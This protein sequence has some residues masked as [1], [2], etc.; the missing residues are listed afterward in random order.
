VLDK[1][2]VSEYET[3]VM[4]SWVAEELKASRNFKGGFDKGLWAGLAHGGVVQH[5]TKEKEP[6][7][8]A[9]RTRD[10]A[11]TR[12]ALE[13]KK[14]DY[15]KHDGKITFDILD[16]LTRSGTNHDHD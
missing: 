13:C 7:T 15:P 3:N 5:V 4:S 10:S 2:E 8:L 1:L 16:N 9:H 11:T 14:I 6:W 12:P